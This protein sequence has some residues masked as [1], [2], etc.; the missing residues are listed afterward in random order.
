MTL[1]AIPYYTFPKIGPFN[2]FGFFVAAG[3]LVGAVVGKRHLDRSGIDGEPFYRFA[4]V[5]AVSGIVGARLAY[6]ISNFGDYTSN[7]LRAFALWEG[8]LSF[9]G[10]LI[11]A[12]VVA[13]FWVRRTRMAARP[14]LDAAALGLSVGLGIGRWGCISVGEHFGGPTKFF[15]GVRFLGGFGPGGVADVREPTL[16]DKGPTVV[17]DLVFHNTALYEMLFCFALFGFLVWL[18]RRKP[19]AGTL[20]GV[21]AVLYGT[22]RFLLDLLRVNDNRTLGLT[23]AQWL[24]VALVGL[25]AWYLVRIRRVPAKAV[26]EPGETSAPAEPEP[27][28]RVPDSPEPVDLRAEPDDEPDEEPDEEPTEPAEDEEPEPRDEAAQTEPRP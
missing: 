3:V 13:P 25:G 9:S 20:A 27:E 19:A 26:E 14:F 6:V 10:G 23:G 16:G 5:A 2:T 1:A 17:K 4:W 22:G 21:A 12:A 24:C 7:P 18:R 15:L 11:L 8:G 28:D